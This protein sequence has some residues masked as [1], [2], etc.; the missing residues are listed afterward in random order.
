M[1]VVIIL[2]CNNDHLACSLDTGLVLLLNMGELHLFSEILLL[3]LF[4]DS[5]MTH[6]TAGMYHMA[7]PKHAS[8]S[9]HGLP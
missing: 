7:F 1:F 8:H 5:Q 2:Y 4:K 6:S 9:H 3:N